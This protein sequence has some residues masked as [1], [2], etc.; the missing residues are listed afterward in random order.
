MSEGDIKSYMD[1]FNVNREDAIEGIHD[2]YDNL[3]RE[4]QE[5]YQDLLVGI[6]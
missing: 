3:D 6:H 5:T 4:M 1:E 2:Y